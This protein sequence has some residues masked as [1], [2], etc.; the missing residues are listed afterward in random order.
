MEEKTGFN[1]QAIHAA[2]IKKDPYGALSVPV[3]NAAAFEFDSAEAME[4]AFTGQNQRFCVRPH[5]QSNRTGFRKQDKSIDR[6]AQRYSAKLRH[7][8]H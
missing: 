4:L 1:K 5:F 6:C 7:G 2:G 8:G 3:Y